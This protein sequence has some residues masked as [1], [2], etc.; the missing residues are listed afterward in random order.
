[1]NVISL[2]LSSTFIDVDTMGRW[3]SWIWL[4]DPM[5]TSAFQKWSI[6]HTSIAD[7]WWNWTS[8]SEEVVSELSLCCFTKSMDMVLI[9]QHL[10]T[11]F[12]HPALSGSTSLPLNDDNRWGKVLLLTCNHKYQIIRKLLISS[13]FECFPTVLHISP[14][15]VVACILEQK[16]HLKLLLLLGLL[17]RRWITSGMEIGISQEKQSIWH[18]LPL[19]PCC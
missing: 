7:D 15:H 10:F 14:S 18:R 6:S 12:Q 13:V 4:K 8:L 11:W 19:H 2:V 3:T 1:M 17:K 9:L 5:T 16:V